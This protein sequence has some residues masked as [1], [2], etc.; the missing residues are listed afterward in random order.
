MVIAGLISGVATTGLIALVN[1]ALTGQGFHGINPRMAFAVLCIGLPLFRF[2]SQALLVNLTQRT[3]Y[4]MRINWCRRILTT[5]IRQL[6]QIG[7]H[8]L[9]ASL[10]NDLGAITDALL[11]LPLLIMH[12]G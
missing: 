8:R 2:L 11:I 1:R 4:Q 9:L 12:M 5:P 10:T 3:L 6:K 7:P